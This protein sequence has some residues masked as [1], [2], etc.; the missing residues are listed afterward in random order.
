MSANSVAKSTVFNLTLINYFGI[1]P[2]AAQLSYVA[3]ITYS[4]SATL[5]L[6]ELKVIYRWSSVVA[7]AVIVPKTTVYKN[8][9]PVFTKK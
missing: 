9:S 3:G 4:S 5:S 7:A 8:C 6:P 2:H 1:N